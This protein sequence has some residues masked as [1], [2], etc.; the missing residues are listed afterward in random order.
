MI[1]GI[2]VCLVLALASTSASRL[3]CVWDCVAVEDAA[4]AAAP[5]HEVP[6][7]GPTLT[8][9]NSHCPLTADST[10]IWTAKGSEPQRVRVTLDVARQPVPYEGTL[11][12]SAFN[13][14]GPPP[15][16]HARG[17]ARQTNSV[18]RI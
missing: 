8:G 9:S 12:A 7:S 13:V 11:F 6:V 15:L 10:A 17:A 1:R 4:H 18:L 3:A 14:T 5:C 2:T 16:H